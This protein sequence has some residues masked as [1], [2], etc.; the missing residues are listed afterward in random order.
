MLTIDVGMDIPGGDVEIPGQFRLQP[1][2]V[3]GRPGTDD[4]VLRDTGGAVENI[5]QHI[6]RIG[7]NDKNGIGRM[8]HDLL[9]D[10]LD[11]AGVGLDQVQP[12]LTGLSRNTGGDDDNVGP[13]GVSI[14]AAADNSGA[15]VSGALVDV[16]RLAVGLVLFHINQ[17]NLTGDPH[18]HSVI[19]NCRADTAGAN[20]R[21]FAHAHTLLLLISIFFC[22]LP[23]LTKEHSVAAQQNT[24]IIIIYQSLQKLNS[25]FAK[26]LSKFVNVS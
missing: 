15:A 24:S 19:G 13:L 8:G 20:N 6:H 11:N 21:Y 5:G 22:I 3:K 26:N 4:A 12:G 16:Q 2:G 23:S 10:I 18:N 1:G 14:V 25:A 9:G 17:D 7:H